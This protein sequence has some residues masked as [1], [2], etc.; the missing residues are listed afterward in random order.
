MSFMKKVSSFRKLLMITLLGAASAVNGQVHPLAYGPVVNLGGGGTTTASNWYKDYVG[1]RVTV[2]SPSSV[3]GDKQNIEATIGTGAS[4][5]PNI[6]DTDLIN[7][8]VVMPPSTDSYAVTTFAPG[9]MTGKICVLWRGPIVGAVNFSTKALYAQNAGALACII[10]N[11]YPGQGP[12]GPGY[13]SGFITIPVYVIGNL[14]GIAIA[15]AYNLL[16]GGVGMN[17]TITH[18]GQGLTQDLGF[19][20]EGYSIWH[21]N[22]IP[23]NQLAS[24]GN[25]MAYYGLGG[26]FIA[27]FGTNAATNVKVSDSLSFTPAGGGAATVLHTGVSPTLTTFNPIDSIYAMFSSSEYT[28]APPAGN[29]TFNLT[30]KISST[31]TDL[32]PGDNTVSYSFYTSDSVYSK[33]RYDLVNRT[34]LSSSYLQF[35]TTTDFLW[36]NMYYVAHGGA[37]ISSVQFSIANKNSIFG[38]IGSGPM[39]I[40]VFK[41]VDGD[42]TNITG[43][44]P[45]SIVENGEL[46]P[47]ALAAYPF[48][49]PTDT[50]ELTFTQIMGDPSTG[51]PGASPILLTDN[52]WYYVAVEVVGGY[53]LGCDGFLSSYPRVYGRYHS[54]N[55][56]FEY[57]GVQ[58]GGDYN[59]GSTPLTG[60]YGQGDGPCAGSQTGL[61]KSVDSFNFAGM[62]G[63]IPSVALIVNNNPAA[64]DHSG[65]QNVSKPFA[66]VVLSPNPAK[67]V[68]NVS[69]SLDKPASAVSYTIIDGLARFVSKDVHN[70]VQNEN[71][72]ISTSNL[73]SGNYFLVINANGQ[74]MVKKFVVVK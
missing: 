18:W 29:G 72:S 5:W 48:S 51:V 14:D 61:I 62:K 16:P 19:V 24:S 33:S 17:M 45:D 60:N 4:E 36:G 71:Y 46:T 34:P 9:S 73:A 68:L 11:E 49:S 64:V 54:S 42:P 3:S 10:I 21:N 8:P 63:L 40:F 55:H 7:I 59:S 23:A 27:N 67:D 22:V 57:P 2:V 50:S 69:L 12:V 6:R 37:A 38:Q 32:Y 52:T 1:R 15:N 43:N 30:Y 13:S 74:A 58:W 39:N 65:V 28:I 56:N 26:A 70:N 25:P 53:Y 41:W 66:N 31:E 20:P 35:G 44:V 47:V